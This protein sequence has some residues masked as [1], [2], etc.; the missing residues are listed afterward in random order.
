MINI[1]F[2]RNIVLFLWLVLGI[3]FSYAQQKEHILMVGN[4]FTFYYNLP[5]TIEQF[6]KA[7]GLKWKINQSTASGATFKQ[8]WQNKK[9]LKTTQRLK[10]KK[11]TQ[12]IFQEHSTYPI[13]AL[14]T[15][16]KYFKKLIRSVP[17][18]T[19]KHLYAT[20]AYPKLKN[21]QNEVIT[22]TSIEKALGTV[23]P[24]SDISILPVGRAF[25]LFQSRYPNQT[26]FT[27]DK[28][29]PNP[30]GSYLAACVI[31]SKISGLSS[32]GL[33]RR[34]ASKPRKGKTLYYFIVEKKMAEN[35]Q[36]IA[37]EIVFNH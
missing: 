20:W 29:H 33:E 23:S 18:N 19:K 27:S 5:T 22:S 28:K 32:L 7:K 12:I 9:G 15:T 11:Y 24:Q 17:V 25:D 13:T 6:A 35:C 21:K 8:H 26:L 34:V 2:T 31:F 1:K 16:Q 3:N 37:D 10:R 36:R 4:S 30:I 14:D